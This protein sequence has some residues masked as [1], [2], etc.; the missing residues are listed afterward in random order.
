MKLL[1]IVKSNKP[2]KKMM[3]VFESDSGRTKTIHFGAR[4]MDDFTIT[5]DV[6]Q[7]ERYLKRHRSSENWSKADS[8]GALSR[9]VLWSATT[10]EEGIR[11]YKK[12]FNL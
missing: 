10:L 3:A 1:K 2:E 5:K 11:N 9:W 7:M 12:R 4:G 6:D 8:A